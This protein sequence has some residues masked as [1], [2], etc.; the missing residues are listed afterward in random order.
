[1]IRL[2][3]VKII[4]YKSLKKII[5]DLDD[6]LVIVGKNNCGKTNI[7]EAIN[8]AFNY[9]SITKEDVHI[10]KIDPF[11]TE[12]KVIIELMFYPVDEN[13]K[14][15][16]SFDDSWLSAFGNRIS[17]SPQTGNQFFAFKTELSYNKN[18]E[19]Y[20][21]KKYVIDNWENETESI[22]GKSINKDDLDAFFT[23]YINAQRDLALDINDRSS[24]W[25]KLTSSIKMEAEDEKEVINKIDEINDKI[26]KN[27]DIFEKISANLKKTTS[28]IESNVAIV[29]IT[30]D[31]T[32]LYKGMNVYYDDQSTVLTSIER[33]G[34]GV[35]SWGN[36]SI[37]KSY[38]ENEAEKNKNIDKAFHSILLVE[39]PESHL[40]PQAQRHFISNIQEIQGQKIITTHSPYILSQ[41]N[42][43]KILF[44]RKEGADTIVS[45]LILDGI[46][47]TDLIDINNKVMSTRGELLY[48]SFVIL[49]EGETEEFTLPI[50]FKKFF[51]KEPYELG[52]TIISV[53]GGQYKPFIEILNR[54]KIEWCIFSD[55]EEN[56]LKNIKS[57]FKKLGLGQIKNNSFL[58][59]IPDEQCIETYLVNSGYDVEINKAIDKVENTTNFLKQYKF[60]QEGQ[61]RKPSHAKLIFGSN[62]NTEKKYKDV[63]SD[64]I[65]L[66]DC[67]LENK[68]EYSKEIAKMI[69]ISSKELPELIKTMFTYVQLKING[70]EKNV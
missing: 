61:S 31:L 16:E 64:K 30:K 33:L 12:K 11:N 37:I 10:S 38:I 48:S 25:F 24:Q 14:E 32:H 13:G 7:L 56:A 50:Y 9:S 8:L 27:N 68:I 2:K 43:N 65:A 6:D 19:I 58:Y 44:V 23:M 36:F 5:L 59:Y 18:K 54:L 70:G 39:E 67:I 53:D 4:N 15:M 52:V 62:N 22:S 3:K 42:L 60:Q 57:L 21:N 49:V 34:L 46:T 20:T 1:M 29:P 66:M 26:V 45:K 63:G 51:N 55:G 69:A 17:F 47:K 35:R 40:H 28:D 41:I